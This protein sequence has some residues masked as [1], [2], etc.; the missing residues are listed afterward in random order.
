MD[1]V[2]QVILDWIGGGVDQF[3]QHGLAVHQLDHGD[4]LG[5]PEVLPSAAE[6]VLAPCKHLVEML[7]KLRIR[8]EPIEDHGMIVIR[9][10]TRQQHRDRA[11][12]GGLAQAI[13]K[14]VVGLAVGPE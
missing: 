1:A 3:V 2:H 7:E 14:R 6:C 8:A 13:G 11:P 10:R 5:R 4:L 9:H 12:L